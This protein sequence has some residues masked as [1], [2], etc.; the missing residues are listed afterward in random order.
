MIMEY[1]QSSAQI[2]SAKI[3]EMCGFTKQQARTVTERMREEGII[4]LMGK[5]PAAKYVKSVELSDN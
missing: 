5:G 1:L 3:Q 4:I 2:T